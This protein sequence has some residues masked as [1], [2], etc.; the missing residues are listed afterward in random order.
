MICERCHTVLEVGMY[1]FCRRGPQDHARGV[2]TVIGDEIDVTITNGTPHPIRF[3][4]AQAFRDWKKVNGYS[5]A[6]R[7]VGRNGTDKS[8]DTINWCSRMDPVTA[9]NVRILIER[10]FRSGGPSREDPPLDVKAT[11]GE[12]GSE[13]WKA[14][15]AGGH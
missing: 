13:A 14:F 9:E 15:H 8:P 6:V 11:C 7:H 1:P 3:R 10:A 2:S 5:D 4:S 12:V